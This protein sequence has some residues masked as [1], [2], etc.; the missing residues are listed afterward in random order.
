MLAEKD[1]IRKYRKADERARVAYKETD[2]KEKKRRDAA[3]REK[4]AHMEAFEKHQPQNFWFP[5][6]WRRY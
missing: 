2:M 1:E 4:K 5:D 6:V 3:V